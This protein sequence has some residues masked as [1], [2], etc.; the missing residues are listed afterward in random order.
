MTLDETV[1]LIDDFKWFL[2]DQGIVSIGR[3]GGGE[4]EG[5]ADN[6]VLMSTLF[7]FQSNGCD[8]DKVCMETPEITEFV[9]SLLTAI[10]VKD[11]FTDTMMNL[12][13][14][15]LDQFQRIA[16]ECFRRN[17]INVIETVIPG[18]GRTLADYMP[19]LHEY[20]KSLVK[21]LDPYEPVTNSKNFMKF[22]TETESFTR[23]CMFYDE[24]KTEEVYLKG[25]DAFA[26]FAG[27]LN[28]ETTMLRFDLDQNNNIDARNSNRKN[29]V[30]NAYYKVYRGAVTALVEDI[31]GSAFI[32][33]YMA[34]PIFQYLVRYGDV[35]NIE[36]FSSVW[37]FVKF[38]LKRNKQ[39]DI[40]RTTVASI[41][42]VIGDQ[43]PTADAHPYKCEECWRDPTVSC[44]PEGSR[45]DPIGN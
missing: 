7:Q 2:R 17:F 26:V 4:I 9:T 8:S 3:K 31:V 16:P 33:R 27:L 43:S 39:A 21:D 37:R 45:W 28:V 38:I 18:D 42:K 25:N 15:E 5:V 41:L 12:C 11:F 19:F 14:T 32:A 23:A 34:K 35:P 6:L 20:L 29:E 36:N 44:E 22:I 10:E 30:L 1:N 40:S 13:S 24:E